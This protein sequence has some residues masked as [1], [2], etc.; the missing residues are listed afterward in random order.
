MNARLERKMV[1]PL[2]LCMVVILAVGLWNLRYFLILD[3][4]KALGSFTP[5]KPVWVASPEISENDRA[6]ADRLLVQLRQIDSQRWFLHL[7]VVVA[8]G[9]TLAYW[10]KKDRERRLPNS[11]TSRMD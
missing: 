4:L 7:L 6:R 3:E 10:G 11:S 2:V 8:A 5:G 1:V 9:G